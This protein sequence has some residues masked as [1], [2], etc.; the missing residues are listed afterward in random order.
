MSGFF[1]PKYFVWP[2]HR[3]TPE[4][5]SGQAVI[6]IRA[7]LCFH[8]WAASGKFN[9]VRRWIFRR[10]ACIRLQNPPWTKLNLPAFASAWNPRQALN[11]IKPIENTIF[12]KINVHLP[13]QKSA[14]LYFWL[15]FSQNIT[16][17]CLY[18]SHLR[19]IDLPQKK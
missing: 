15:F 1:F 6:P 8:C 11:R 17:K 12:K 13:F 7:C 9:A 16:V 10:I 2:L 3:C 19:L 4:A 14:K 5:S 18:S